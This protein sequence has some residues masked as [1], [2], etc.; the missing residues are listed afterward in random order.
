MRVEAVRTRVCGTLNHYF[1]QILAVV[2]ILAV[3]FSGIILWLCVF[4]FQISAQNIM[5]TVGFLIAVNLMLM[6]SIDLVVI[7]C[8]LWS[9]Y[10]VSYH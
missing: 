3:G 7:G 5:N 4:G 1:G 6:V 10:L 9:L 2:A 8:G